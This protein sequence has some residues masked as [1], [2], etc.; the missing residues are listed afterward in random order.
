MLRA[1]F[2]ALKQTNKAQIGSRSIFSSICAAKKAAANI[3]IITS[4]KPSIDTS[5]AFYTV[6]RRKLRTKVTKQKDPKQ[7]KAKPAAPTPAK[8]VPVVKDAFYY[9]DKAKDLGNK[10]RKNCWD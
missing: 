8:N 1:V 9:Y 4:H 2:C 5:L 7:E 3:N 6:N 10:I